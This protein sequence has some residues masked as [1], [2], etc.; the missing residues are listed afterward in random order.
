MFEFY[1]Q[2]FFDTKT[3]IISGT[4]ALIKWVKPDG[5]IIYP[6]SFIPFFKSWV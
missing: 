4:E 6:D 5:N 3:G 1:Y 2:P